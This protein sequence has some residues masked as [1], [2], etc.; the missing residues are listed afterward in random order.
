MRV[1]PYCKENLVDDHKRGVLYF[2]DEELELVDVG[3]SM[4]SGGVQEIQSFVDDGLVFPPVGEEIELWLQ[5]KAV[6]F[7]SLE[8]Q[9][10]LL[11][12]KVG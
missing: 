5:L 2:V 12:Q 9:P 7:N 1:M 11:I 3:V 6:R 10:Y 8:I 4:I